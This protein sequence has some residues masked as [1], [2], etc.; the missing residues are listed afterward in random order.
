MGMGNGLWE[1]AAFNS[2]L[3][4][5]QAGLGTS[6][7]D[8]SKWKLTNDYGT[9][10]NNGNVAS[11]TLIAPG[12]SLTETYTYDPLNRL[13]HASETN[14]GNVQQWQQ[15]FEYDRYG[16]RQINLA[17]TSAEM[18]G[19]N[20]TVWTASAPS[21][22]NRI[23]GGN[24][25]YDA[26]GNM[27]KDKLGTTTISYDAENRQTGYGQAGYAYDGDGKRIKKTW[28]G[29]TTIF[30]YDA[31]GKLV[32]EYTNAAV[33]AQGGTS[34]LTQ[35]HLGSTRVVTDGSGQVKSRLDYAPFGEKLAAGTGGRDA[36]QGYVNESVKQKFTGYERDSETGLDF[37]QARYYSNP[38]GRFLSV[39]PESA[40]AYEDDPQSWNA[41]AY[42]RN[43]PLLYTDPDGEEYVIC[44]PDG[45]ECQKGIS[46]VNF[47]KARKIGGDFNFGG[48]GDFYEG[49]NITDRD[50]NVV[51]VFQQ[52]SID[53]RV[54]EFSYQMRERT[55]GH[56]AKVRG[57]LEFSADMATG[58]WRTVGK[59]V[60]KG[61]ARFI[62][63]K[64]TFS[65]A[66]RRR[67]AKRLGDIP[68][69]NRPIAEGRTSGSDGG[70]WWEYRDRNG[71][72]KIVVEHP[73]GSVHVGTPKPQ[74]NHRAGEPPRYF[75]V[76][77]SGHV[78]DDQ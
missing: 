63:N 60:T 51:A 52:V 44:T 73:D 39:D 65:I 70:R 37:A 41:Y 54:K 55:K 33:Q 32:A 56:G 17:T 9:T 69:R 61:I 22:T 4:M 49:G 7:T 53:D 20:P 46:D 28:D 76:P 16:N 45:K 14:A 43:N 1:S 15:G 31:L 24:Y 66:G 78:G 62:R 71:N 64:S 6:A 75:P 12:L 36:A 68:K 27:T 8:T 25:D 38:Q 18:I 57:F 19:E 29:T 2:R 13:T 74:S 59:G 10:T 48:N 77:G 50:G 67:L 72:T 3:Q 5:T 42:A 40:G 21:T 26:A 47:R 11:Q 58:G 23:T 35:D 34:Y 30:V